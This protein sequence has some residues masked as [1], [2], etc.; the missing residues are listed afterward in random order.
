MVAVPLNVFTPLSVREPFAPMLTGPAKMF[1]LLN[2]TLPPPMV[3]APPPMEPK[4]PKVYACATVLL[5]VRLVGETLA[6][7]V[8]E[9][10]D[11]V[12]SKITASPLTNR[13]V[14]REL[15]QLG[16]TLSQLTLERPVHK[17]FCAPISEAGAKMRA[18]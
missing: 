6:G 2:V 14:G 8:M 9:N 18:Q 4:P 12:L 10:C 16:A 7:T 5:K 11:A 15:V 1:A 3:T 17:S 13:F